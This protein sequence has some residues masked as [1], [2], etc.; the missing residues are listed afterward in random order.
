M[1]TRTFKIACWTD[2]PGEVRYVNGPLGVG[3][4]A[5]NDDKSGAWSLADDA[6]LLPHLTTTLTRA[7]TE[8]LAR[9]LNRTQGAVRQRVQRLRNEHT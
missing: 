9:T 2:N 8:R 5:L 3:S 1:A 6:L 7:T 4:H